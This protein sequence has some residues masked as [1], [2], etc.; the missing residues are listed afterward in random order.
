[1]ARCTLVG[2]RATALAPWWL[3]CENCT[4]PLVDAPRPPNVLDEQIAAAG[5]DATAWAERIAPRRWG[6]AGDHDPWLRRRRALVV[7]TSITARAHPCPL[8]APL[9][10]AV[11]IVV[12]VRRPTAL[13][14]P[15]CAEPVVAATTTTGH[16][17]DRCALAPVTPADRVAVLVGNSLIVVAQTCPGC[18]R[19]VLRPLD[20]TTVG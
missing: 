19:A 14:C 4:L 10:A 8:A 3:L 2:C 12:P 17:C 20:D 13:A 6:H 16:A 18:A 5:W 7:A 1:M 15:P 11:P 9:D